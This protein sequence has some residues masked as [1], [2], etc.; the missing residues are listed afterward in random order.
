MKNAL[1][2]IEDFELERNQLEVQEG[3]CFYLYF[4]YKYYLIYNKK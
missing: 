1:T 3:S 4:R 2:D